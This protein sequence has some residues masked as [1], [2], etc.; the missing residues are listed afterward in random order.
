MYRALCLS[1]REFDELDPGMKEKPETANGSEDLVHRQ[2]WAQQLVAAA[3]RF[4]MPVQE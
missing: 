1:I 3:G 4:G 2:P